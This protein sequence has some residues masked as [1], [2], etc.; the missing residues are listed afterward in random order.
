MAQTLLD[1]FSK[2]QG[3][4]LAEFE[5]LLEAATR[6]PTDG[7]NSPLAELRFSPAIAVLPA[8]QQAKAIARVAEYRALFGPTIF[9]RPS[10]ADD[11]AQLAR[12]EHLVTLPAQH[13]EEVARA[14]RNAREKFKLKDEPY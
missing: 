8:A 6:I 1:H 3:A 5:K 10:V 11:L 13:R 2:L 7:G 14:V 9:T 4:T 12:E